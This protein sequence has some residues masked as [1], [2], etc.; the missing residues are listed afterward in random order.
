[1]FDVSHKFSFFIIFI[2][3]SE[4][5]LVRHFSY[6]IQT[7]K[8]K[9]DHITLITVGVRQHQ[10]ILSYHCWETVRSL[11]STVWRPPA[12][13]VF[14]A[15]RNSNVMGQSRNDWS[16]PSFCVASHAAVCP[17]ESSLY[18][19]LF[20]QIQFKVNSCGWL[21]T[22]KKVFCFS[23]N[24]MPTVCVW[25]GSR[26]DAKQIGVFYVADLFPEVAKTHA[27][28]I[29]LDWKGRSILRKPGRSLLSPSVLALASCT[30]THACKAQIADVIWSYKYVLLCI[31]TVNSY[32]CA[33]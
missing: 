9:F 3:R 12:A 19:L 1:M 17:L 30:Q 10:Q 13:E 26:H 28:K 11:K 2:E 32:S 25:Q 7:A 4:S 33:D 23:L 22:K 21:R 24:S 14:V 29:Q 31:V 15:S 20:T 8:P 16:H 5:Q 18:V 6:V 27:P